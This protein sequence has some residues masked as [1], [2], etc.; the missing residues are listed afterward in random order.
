[1]QIYIKTPRNNTI[2]LQVDST[3]SISKVKKILC[4]REG[5]PITEQ[6]LLFSGKQLEDTKTIAYYAIKQDSTLDLLLRL[7]GGLAEMT[8]SFD[9]NY[10]LTISSSGI[11]TAQVTGTYANGS[12]SSPN[13]GN[14]ILKNR[15]DSTTTGSVP[16]SNNK[17]Y[18][19]DYS[20]SGT[21]RITFTINIT[22][23]E[24][25]SYYM[26][27]IRYVFYIETLV[28]PTVAT[29][30]EITKYLFIPDSPSNIQ[31]AGNKLKMVTVA[32]ISSAHKSVI[33][34]PITTKTPVMHF[35]ITVVHSPYIFQII[36]YFTL[37]TGYVLYDT[38]PTFDSTIDGTSQQQLYLDGLNRAI[39]LVSDGTNWTVVNNYSDTL[40]VT[41][42]IDST[43][44]SP[45]LSES[46][47]KV[48]VQYSFTGSGQG[49]YDKMILRA[50]TSSY[51]KYIFL[52]N[53]SGSSL[54]FMLYFPVQAGV[55]NIDTLGLGYNTITLTIADTR[56]A[57]LI[58]TFLNGKY[59]I[60]FAGV[61]P[62]YFQ[63][64]GYE[65]PTIT[66]TKTVNFIESAT[67]VYMPS[68]TTSNSFCKLLFLKARGVTNTIL[69]A[70]GTGVFIMDSTYTAISMDTPS[71][72][73]FIINVNNDISAYLPVC[74]F[75]GTGLTFLTYPSLGG[76]EGGGGV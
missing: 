12:P 48:A 44:P 38:I 10:T 24:F 42:I 36:P 71:V 1:M 72:L 60:I 33:L 15:F 21:F 46:S 76:G 50:M 23:S 37:P 11:L 55:D 34:P 30:S 2:S 16:H 14:F 59:Y 51:L 18:D 74:F 17:T 19:H 54:S 49:I 58:I 62:F 52:K 5:I 63:A 13:A 65:T 4:D 43:L 47:E 45:I 56:V 25:I 64:G 9:A 68:I 75:L 28:V 29:T 8:V 61:I 41:S 35:K 57:G 40:T 26:Q 73:W 22:D 66:L 3:Y 32:D 7:R 27:L 39:S 6:R 31:M 70:Q 53:S 20:G 69:V 67:R